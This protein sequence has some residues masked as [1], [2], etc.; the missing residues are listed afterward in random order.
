MI[1]S[2]AT[3]KAFDKTQHLFMIKT[4][5]KLQREG[6]FLHLKRN[7]YKIPTANA[8]LNEKLNAFPLTSTTGQGCLFIPFL[9]NTHLD[10]SP[11]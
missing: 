4:L 5:S 1:T 11:R 8:I 2:T 9:L 10:G 6:N 7:I 3:E